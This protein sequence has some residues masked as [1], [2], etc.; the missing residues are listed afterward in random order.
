MWQWQRDS[1]SSCRG[2]SVAATASPHVRRV[3]VQAL[4][5][6][7]HHNAFELAH[8]PRSGTKKYW[9]CGV[10]FSRPAHPSHVGG[11]GKGRRAAETFYCFYGACAKNLGQQGPPTQLTWEPICW[12]G[13]CRVACCHLGDSRMVLVCWQSTFACA[14]S[15]LPHCYTATCARARPCQSAGTG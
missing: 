2:I 9:K 14:V 7:A 3:Y 5:A 15:V 4:S 1:D 6:G 10:F 12:A 11:Q 8:A 13:G